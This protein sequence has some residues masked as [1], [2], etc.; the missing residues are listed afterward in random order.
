MLKQR[1]LTALVL[2]PL[3]LLVLFYLPPDAFCFLIAI[4]V[5]G[6][7]WEWTNLMEI[8]KTGWRW[9][10]LL[11]MA[12]CLAIAARVPV[13]YTIS[14][15]AIWWVMALI[16]VLLYPLASETWGKSVTLRGV[17]G[18]LVL[19]PCWTAICF[20]RKNEAVDTLLF[21]FILIWGADTA[22]Y[23][24]GKKWGKNKLAPSVSPGKSVQGFMGALVFTL[25]LVLGVVWFLDIPLNLWVWCFGLSLLT[26]IFSV[27]GDLF[28]SML[29]RKVGLKDS[30]RLLP[31]HGG[32]LDRIDSLTAAA[33]IFVFGSL[34]LGMI[35][36]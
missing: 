21:L 8:K 5:L 34:M 30:G 33:P 28:E 26:V 11:L 13:L 6:A 24:V 23:F 27:I 2:I 1:V 14:A 25:V 35:Q 19:V 16:L 32:L 10:Y 9:L 12:V 29:K 36:V 17:M 20:I 4:I 15:A 18:I 31:G 3:T 7:A 22:A